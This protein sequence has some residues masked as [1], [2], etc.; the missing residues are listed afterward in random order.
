VSTPPLPPAAQ[1][2]P[3]RRR[4]RPRRTFGRVRAPADGDVSACATRSHLVED[5][6]G[7]TGACHEGADC[8][9][10]WRCA[11]HGAASANAHEC[12]M[13]T[14]SGSQP[15]DVE[16]RELRVKRARRCVCRASAGH[17]GWSEPRRVSRGVRVGGPTGRQP[18]AQQHGRGRRAP[19]QVSSAR[20]QRSLHAVVAALRVCELRLCGRGPDG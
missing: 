17:L 14:A 15:D 1:H 8:Q 16:R 10:V 3:R 12:A 4:A 18:R 5:T 20:Q 19:T 6:P 9:A 11:L 2:T 13:V 7:H